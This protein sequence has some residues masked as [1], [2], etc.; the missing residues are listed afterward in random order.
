MMAPEK[1]RIA[2]TTGL[3]HWVLVVHFAAGLTGLVTG[4]VALALP[5]GSKLHRS[6]GR[7]FVYAMV[8]M[9]FLA[10]G[11]AA[12]GGSMS[13][14]GG[15]FAAYL[16]FTGMTTVRPLQR[17]PQWWKV[18][19]GLFALTFGVLSIIDGVRVMGTPTGTRNG[20]PFGM[21]LFLGTIG[22]LAG[23]GDLRAIRAGALE[24]T[25]RLARH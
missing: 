24:G 23:A 16:V 14:L 11:I 18:G 22:V 10:A 17:E 7:V 15:F 21:L 13:P 1:L 2:T 20:V 9:G 25:R 3:I 8:T 5:K 6:F 19:L 4:F 12:Y